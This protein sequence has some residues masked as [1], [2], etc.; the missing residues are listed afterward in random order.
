M[1]KTGIRKLSPE[2]Q[3]VIRGIIIRMKEQNYPAKDKTFQLPGK[4][5]LKK[6]SS[7]EYIAEDVTE[8][9]I[10]RPKKPKRAVFRQKKAS[11]GKDTGNH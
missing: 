1:E 10:N 5:V 8:S 7:I 9:P 2:K 4:K 3:A 6:A 11:Y